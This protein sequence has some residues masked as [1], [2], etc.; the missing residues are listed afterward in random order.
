MS[1]A[2]FLRR[3]GLGLGL[4]FLL[5][6]CTSLAPEV[7]PEPVAEAPATRAD[8]LRDAFAGAN[9]IVIRPQ[10]LLGLRPQPVELTDP[11]ILETFVGLLTFDEDYGPIRYEATP[12][13][14][15]S[16]FQGETEL[17]TLQLQR[18]DHLQWPGGPWTGDAVLTPES[19]Q[20]LEAWSRAAG[21]DL[22]AV[23]L[24]LAERE[25]Q[26]TTRAMRQFLAAFNPAAR[27]LFALSD[28]IMYAGSHIR[29]VDTPLADYYDDPLDLAETGFIALT[30]TPTS[31]LEDDWSVAAVQSAL[32]ELDPM[33]VLEA[34]RMLTEN[35]PAFLGAARYFFRNDFGDQ[36][37]ESIRGSLAIDLA[38]FALRAGAD[39]DKPAVL[40]Y[41]AAF[42]GDE[43]T[44]FL[45]EIASGQRTYS[46]RPPYTSTSRLLDEPG[47]PY[48]AALWLAWRD[49]P[50]ASAQV[51]PLP[52]T[53]PYGPDAAALEIAEALR[54]SSAPLT[55]A[56]FKYRSRTLGLAAVKAMAEPERVGL[57]VSVLKASLAH[58]DPEVARM[59]ADV[60][61]RLG[62]QSADPADEDP[63]RDID[64]LLAETHPRLAIAEYTGQMLGASA[65]RLAQLLELRAQ[66]YYN[67]GDYE[68]AEIDY[69][70][71]ITAIPVGA[72]NAR[73][74]LAWI[75]WYLGEPEAAEETIAIAL[76]AEPRAD[77]LLLRGI[78]R[79]SEEQ[80]GTATDAD[81]IAATVLDPLEGYAPLFQHYAAQLDGRPGESRLREYFLTTGALDEWPATIIAYALGV[82]PGPQLLQLAGIGTPEVVA[83]HSCEANFYLAQAARVDGRAQ[84][85][86]RYLEAC[87]ATNQPHVAEFWVAR[88]RLQELNNSDRNP[89]TPSGPAR[90]DLI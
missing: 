87:V 70:N 29:R 76:L 90:G 15:F 67:L 82:V 58:A 31:W 21:A 36:L 59:S 71:R 7:A 73:A 17:G 65:T 39:R 43:A 57:P 10:V 62:L 38:D 69:L 53:G 48:A 26:E 60:A 22:T 33:D 37:P 83:W 35:D 85:E 64:P 5:V 63:G 52:A 40:E 88:R 49:D 47:L 6:A 27:A 32:N 13:A 25:G 34:I 45:T 68:L 75:Q 2:P 14:E 4:T 74:R 79:Y 41:L 42:P 44:L 54:D 80:F 84:D 28:S 8:Q 12:D 9:R 24:G 81:L 55:V 16:F 86:R 11:D 23:I 20:S 72:D 50:G 89:R 19:V 78:M 66:A 51:P 46:Y 61:F 30:E 56:H 3:L 77:L 1:P 18:L